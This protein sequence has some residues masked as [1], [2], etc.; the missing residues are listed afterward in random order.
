MSMDLK[1]VCHH[2][3]SEVGDFCK[4]SCSVNGEYIKQLKVILSVL[5][6]KATG[7][8]STYRYWPNAEK[9]SRGE[10]RKESLPHAN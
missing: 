6:L 3:G 10:S 4:E 2:C 9:L 1:V 5:D 8:E 7:Y